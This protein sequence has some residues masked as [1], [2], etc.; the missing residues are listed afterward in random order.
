MSHHDHTLTAAHREFGRKNTGERVDDQAELKDVM[1][2]LTK[3][4]T[5]IKSF[6][7]K[8]SA[9]IKANGTMAAETK[10]A[11][12]KIAGDASGLQARLMDVEQK[13]ARRGGPADGPSTKALGE[14]F[15]GTEEFK[16]LAIRGKGSARLQTK[17]VTAITSTTA[18]T[19]GVGAAIRPDRRPGIIAPPDRGM[20]IREPRDARPHG[21]ECD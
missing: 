11:L 6:A 4:D 12:E 19:G 3:R 1:D 17:A 7:E 13:L 21:L 9:E 5:E 20:T 2:A 18:G 16:A 10:A 8:A 15:T 14:Q